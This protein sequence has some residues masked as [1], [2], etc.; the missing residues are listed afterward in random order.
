MIPALVLGLFVIVGIIF[1]IV[2]MIL[3]S[4]AKRKFK[5]CTAITSAKVLKNVKERYSHNV[6]DPYYDY[7][8]HPVFEYY[9]GEER[10]EREYTIGTSKV[11]YQDGSSINIL[12][13]PNKPTM[14]YVEGDKTQ[15]I[16]GKVFK[17]AGIV[18]IFTAIVSGI[19]VTI[20][21]DNIL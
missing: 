15:S 18:C 19:L 12:Y 2:G 13:N 1:F 6:S 14:F 5:V 9:V 16:L 17:I 20:A 8:I 4:N 11:K 10:F 21:I 7:L 3:S